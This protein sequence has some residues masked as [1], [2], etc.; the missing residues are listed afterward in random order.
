MATA[1]SPITF[2]RALHRWTIAG[3]RV[4]ETV[5]PPRLRLPVH[6]HADANVTIV[7]RGT[8]DEQIEKRAFSAARGSVIIKP[9]GARHSNIYGSRE[10]ECVTIEVPPSV[11]LPEAR[12]FT[13]PVLSLLADRL[14]DEVSRPDATSELVAEEL[15]REIARTAEQ[16]TKV[17]ETSAKWLAVI[18]EMLRDET[19]SPSLSILGTAVGRHPAHVAR[20]FRARYGCSIG[21]FVRARRIDGALEALRESRRPI[22]EIALDAGFYDQSHFTNVFRRL[23]GMTPDQYRTQRS[24]NT[25]RHLVHKIVPARNDASNP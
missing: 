4:T 16:V 14:L 9:A 2:G 12:H 11:A 5:H 6:D 10:V 19:S 15:I 3:F 1:R 20:A 18:E 23:R 17:P 7:L 24:S 22:A 21:A 13:A 8:F 25:T